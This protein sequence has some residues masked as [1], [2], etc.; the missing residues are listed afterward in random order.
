MSF[1]LKAP[2]NERTAIDFSEDLLIHLLYAIFIPMSYLFKWINTSKK[3]FYEG[4]SL[5]FFW[6]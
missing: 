2:S 5:N 6:G 3:N 1:F 4:V